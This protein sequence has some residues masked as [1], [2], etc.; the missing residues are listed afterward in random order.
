MPAVIV[1][2]RVHVAVAIE[3]QVARVAGTGCVRRSTPREPVAADTGQLSGRNAVVRIRT[4]Q[5]RSG[6]RCQADTRRENQRSTTRLLSRAF[7]SQAVNA[8]AQRTGNPHERTLLLSGF[9]LPL[10]LKFK[11]PAL[12]EPA[13]FGEALQEYPLLP[14]LSN[15]PAETPP[16][17]FARRNPDAGNIK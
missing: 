12:P 16:F 7:S 13:A 14:T 9:T 2:E 4:A 11:L 17:V 6:S 1:V 3:V 15:S 8:R 5:P 10:L